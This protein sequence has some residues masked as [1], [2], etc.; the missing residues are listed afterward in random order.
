MKSARE[1]HEGGVS[2]LWWWAGVGVAGGE[3]QHLVA[4]SELPID[5]PD[6][7]NHPAVR[8]VIRIED[9]SAKRLVPSGGGRRHLAVSWPGARA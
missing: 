1:R 7:D 2:P 8:V 5:D 6:E 4:L 3:S 9:E